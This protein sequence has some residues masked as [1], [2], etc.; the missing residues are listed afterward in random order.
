MTQLGKEDGTTLKTT[1]KIL[2][3]KSKLKNEDLVVG[4]VVRGDDGAAPPP[5]A[6]DE[7]AGIAGAE[8]ELAEELI[9]LPRKPHFDPSIDRR[10]RKKTA[11]TTGRRR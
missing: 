5:S 9:L 2:M 6:V 4:G 11:A 10:R 3:Q 8:A 7:A 1:N